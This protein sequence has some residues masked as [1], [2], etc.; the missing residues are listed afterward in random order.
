MLENTQ[1]LRRGRQHW[2]ALAC[3]APCSSPQHTCCTPL[4]PCRSAWPPSLSQGRAPYLWWWEVV[5]GCSPFPSSPTAIVK[6]FEPTELS[7]SFA[8]AGNSMPPRGKAFSSPSLSCWHEFKLLYTNVHQ[9]HGK[10][11][12]KASLT[13]TKAWVSSGNHRN[14]HT[15][16]SFSSREPADQYLCGNSLMAFRKSHTEPAR[17]PIQLLSVSAGI[18][19]FSMKKE[20]SRLCCI[21]FNSHDACTK[22]MCWHFIFSKITKKCSETGI[23][24]E[25]F[26]G[27]SLGMNNFLVSWAP[28]KIAHTGSSLWA[29]HLLCFS[30]RGCLRSSIKADAVT[31]LCNIPLETNNLQLKNL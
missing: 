23:S 18:K 27:W 6:L 30:H 12:Y 1:R 16:P 15:N 13:P 19:I 5:R 8:L 21:S 4:S 3:R 11:T 10:L 20:E 31:L 28:H 26:E 22:M 14:P 29:P 17:N 7:G 2:C 25:F 9:A 24:E